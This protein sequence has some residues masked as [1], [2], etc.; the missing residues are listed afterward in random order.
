MSE[1]WLLLLLCAMATYFWR[2]LG[3]LLSGRIKV[4]SELFRWVECVAYAMVTG[5][6]ARMI[7]MPTGTLAASP[8]AERLLACAVALLCYR[9][10]RRNLFAGVASGVAVMVAAAYL[11][12]AA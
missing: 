7:V 3:V 2:G 10:T 1:L 9:L 12:A 6:I 5:L 4:E 11:R 8:L